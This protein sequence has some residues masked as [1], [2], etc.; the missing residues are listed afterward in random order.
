MS[1]VY[2]VPTEAGRTTSSHQ[3]G[4]LTSGKFIT[5]ELPA[6]RECSLSAT[7]AGGGNFGG[8]CTQIT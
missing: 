2:L 6:Y 7:L 1:D 4:S 3:R 5:A 8:R